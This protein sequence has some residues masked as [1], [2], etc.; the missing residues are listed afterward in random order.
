MIKVGDEIYSELTNSKAVV[1]RIDTWHRYQCFNE[2]GAQFILEETTFNKY[3]VKTGKH[4]PQIEEVLE[5]L[6]EGKERE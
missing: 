3:W 5:G 2:I 4:Y 6:K 1:H